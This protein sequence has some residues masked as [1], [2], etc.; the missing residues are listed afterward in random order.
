MGRS[1]LLVGRRTRAPHTSPA[2]PHP[3]AISKRGGNIALRGDGFGRLRRNAPAD[4][5]LGT[6]PTK[7]GGET[8]SA[9]VLTSAAEG[10]PM[11]QR[12]SLALATSLLRTVAA[13]ALRTGFV[14]RSLLMGAIAGTLGV[15]TASGQPSSCDPTFCAL[16]TN[17]C[18]TWGC[19]E[20][21]G[22]VPI[23]VHNGVACGDQTETVCSY[24][25]ICS[26]LQC[27]PNDKPA[28][29]ACGDQSE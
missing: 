7:A 10:D 13:R 28:G 20:S 27:R 14:A 5:R 25:D 1:R 6:P 19:R 29:T 11:K 12:G 4:W 16:N 8:L 18:A 9:S 26:N 24:P 22:C 21:L 2:L 17:V 3:R 15:A 23:D